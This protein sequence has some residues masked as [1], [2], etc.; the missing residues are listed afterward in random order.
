[1]KNKKFLPVLSQWIWFIDCI[2]H[3]FS[4]STAK[5]GHWQVWPNF[6][7]PTKYKKFRIWQFNQARILRGNPY[8]DLNP[9]NIFPFLVILHL[10]WVRV[11]FRPNPT[12]TQHVDGFGSGLAPA[13]PNLTHHY[14]TLTLNLKTCTCDIGK[15]RGDLPNRGKSQY[16]TVYCLNV[17]PLYNTKLSHV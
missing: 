3:T 14:L 9:K 1:M 11:G 13:R 4:I 10:W 5:M 2:W 6:N 15:L 7:G 16:Q 8:P 17:S 12:Q